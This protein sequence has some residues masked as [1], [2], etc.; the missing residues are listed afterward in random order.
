MDIVEANLDTE[1]TNLDIV[2]TAF[3]N[4]FKKSCTLVYRGAM[5]KVLES[6]D[7]LGF[8]L[9]PIKCSSSKNR[10]LLQTQ[11]P[12]FFKTD[13]SSFEKTTPDSS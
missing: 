10:L 7:F 4:V 12:H 9:H 13:S 6:E 11:T 8:R 1:L 3:E 5:N 2:K